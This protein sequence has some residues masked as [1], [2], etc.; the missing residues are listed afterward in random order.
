LAE[1]RFFGVPHRV[2][3]GAVKRAGARR[4]GVV[5]ERDWHSVTA[6]GRADW[7]PRIA[8]LWRYLNA[9]RPQGG[10]WRRADVDPVEIPRLL[11]NLWLFDV[12]GPPLDFRYRL[13]GTKIVDSLQADHTGR[14]LSE[15]FPD[16]RVSIDTVWARLEF[17]VESGQPTWRRGYSVAARRDTRDSIE[18]LTV[19]LAGA[20]GRIA[21]IFGYTVIYRVT[22]EEF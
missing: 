8:E 17:M 16:P 13:V 3:V 1:K 18:N 11:A 6:D 12:V 15:V 2:S 22:G 20:D 21:M 5:T 4:A 10:P 7:H 9:K 14:L 19:P